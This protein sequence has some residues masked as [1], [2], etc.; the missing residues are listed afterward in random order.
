MAQVMTNRSKEKIWTA[1]TDGSIQLDDVRLTLGKQQFHFNLTIEAGKITAIT[2][3]S[4]SGKSTL[5]NLISGF[6]TPDQG[7]VLIGNRDV[8]KDLPAERPVASIFQ[9]HNLFAHL[10]LFTNVALGANSA[11]K[12]TAAHRVAISAALSRVGLAGFERRMPADLSGGERQR[13]A[14]ARSLVQNQPLILMDEPFAALDPALRRDMGSLMRE[15]QR[16]HDRTI[17]IVTHQPDEV[18]RLADNVVFLEKG[19]VTFLG[20]KRSFIDHADH[21]AITNFLID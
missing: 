5:L 18:Q 3:P 16:E 14:I 19:A 2:G 7:R 9:D 21:S 15:L 1:M 11:L 10:D 20:D 13:A 12:L 8:S 6:E 4:G 17:I